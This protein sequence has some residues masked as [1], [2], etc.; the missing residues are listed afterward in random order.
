MRVVRWIR[1]MIF[2][3][4]LVLALAACGSNGSHDSQRSTADPGPANGSG[5]DT[6]FPATLS[7]AAVHLQRDYESLRESRQ[8][9]S[10]IWEGL[11]TGTQ[12][13]CGEYPDV[14]SPETLTAEGDP[15]LE[16]LATLL[17]SAAIDIDEAINLWKA[18][19]TRPRANPSPDVIDKGRL[20]VRAAGDALNQAQ[21]L[22]ATFQE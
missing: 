18:E 1:T 5:E 13:R 19:C 12:V 7:P 8:K 6:P 4:L 11:A 17:H 14:M 22:L 10:D 20:A 9:I 2:L 16:P 21:E 15:A 3:S